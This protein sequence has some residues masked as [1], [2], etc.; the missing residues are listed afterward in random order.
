MKDP[1]SDAVNSDGNLFGRL[2]AL[3]AIA[4]VAIGVHL[5]MSGRGLSAVSVPAAVVEAPKPVAV[6]RVRA[7][8]PVEKPMP[9]EVPPAPEPLAP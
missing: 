1:R 5:L 9:A 8:K 2:V 3:V 4:G 6:R 7:P